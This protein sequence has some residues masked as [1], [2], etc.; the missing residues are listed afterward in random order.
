MW[1]VVRLVLEVVALILRWR[2]DP[3]RLRDEVQ[4]ALDAD[5]ER[6]EQAFREAIA[7][8]NAPLVSRRLDAAV[9]RRRDWLRRKN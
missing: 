1:A 5:R 3:E 7:R 6:R 9:R 8:R 4:K 2:L